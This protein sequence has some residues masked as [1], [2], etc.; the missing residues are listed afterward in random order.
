LVM[1]G[2]KRQPY[3]LEKNREFCTTESDRIVE[4]RFLPNRTRFAPLPD[5][6]QW[7]SRINQ[8]G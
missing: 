7:W 3:W 1:M 8:S 2:L 5:E 4:V 6:E